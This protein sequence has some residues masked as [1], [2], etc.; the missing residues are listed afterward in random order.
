M[1]IGLDFDGVICDCGRLKSECA[2]I[3]YGIDAC[4]ADFRER[5]L[6]DR[7][8][9]TESQYRNLQKFVYEDRRAF[10]IMSLVPEVLFFISRLVSENHSLRVI[11]GRTGIGLQIAEEWS[12]SQGLQL[13]F[14]GVGFGKNK[15][16]DVKGLDLYVDDDLKI[17]QPLSGIVPNLFLFSWDYN[18][19]QKEG[20]IAK[21]IASWRELYENIRELKGV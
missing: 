18:F 11:T 17:L 5:L 12:L 1:R 19:H 20:E 4:S 8:R 2:K 15:A 6:V 16:E 7:K 9:L 14:T 13:E 10:P 3:L 21:R